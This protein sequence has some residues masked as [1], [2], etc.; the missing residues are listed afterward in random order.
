M[1]CVYPISGTYGLLPRVLYYCTLALAI[2]GRQKEWLV[3]GAVVGAVTYSGTAAIHAMT[4]ISSKEDAFDLD[5]YGAWAV[6]STGAIGYVTLINWS[7][8]VRTSRA[9][10]VLIAWGVLVGM[11]LI[12]AR[13]ELFDNPLSDGEPPC[14]STPIPGVNSRF[15]NTSKSILLEY[16]IQLLDPVFNCTYK[17]FSTTKPLRQPNE[18]MAVPRYVVTGYYASLTRVMVGIIMW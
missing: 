2:F 9:K 7:E 1:N 8:T 15:Y 14:Y 11:G 16:P 17:C 3:V 18:I 13:V 10:T 4:L 5:A 6:L 12:F